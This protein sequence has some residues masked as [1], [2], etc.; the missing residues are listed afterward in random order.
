MDPGARARRR[1]RRRAACDADPPSLSGPRAGPAAL[2][3]RSA[4]AAHADRPR[5]LARRVR[6]RRHAAS[7][8]AAGRRPQ[9][10][11]RDERATSGCPRSAATTARSRPAGA[12][13]DLPPARVPARWPASVHVTGPM[14]FERAH[15]DIELPPGDEPLVLV[16]SSTERDPGHELARPRSRRSRTSRCTSSSRSTA[17]ARAGAARCP[18]N[19]RVHDWVSYSQLMPG[20]LGRGLPRR[21]RDHLALARRRHAGDR[22]A[23]RRR[24]GGER[25]PGRLVRRRADAAA[26]PARPARARRG[27]PAPAR[28]PELRRARAAR[29]PPGRARTTAPRPGRELVE[30]LAGSRRSGSP[31]VLVAAVGLAGHAL[32]AIALARELDAR[33]AEVVVWTSER[34]RGLLEELGLNGG[35]RSDY[36]AV[37]RRRAARRPRDDAG[38]LGSRPAPGLRAFEPDVVVSDGLTRRRRSPRRSP[39]CR[40][41][42]SFPRS[43]PSTGRG[44][45]RSRRGSA[46]RAPS[47]GAAAWSAGV[48][49]RRLLPRPARPSA[50][51]QRSARGARARARARLPRDAQRRPDPGRDA[52]PSSSTRAAGPSTST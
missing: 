40:A 1:G 49:L 43:T 46:R 8:H 23:A 7:Q 13:R 21:P 9:G 35:P 48:P 20:R 29:P 14:L 42:P 15:P 3:A 25:R 51:V 2:S 11:R 44:C 41:R 26:A 22:L 4:A 18:A 34:W 45:P 27:R 24:H 52:S 47:L 10:P 17:A 16:A 19:A 37:A 5:G 32:P 38:R 39:G 31:R 12:R 50:R 30:D 28:R 6:H 33:G 36:F